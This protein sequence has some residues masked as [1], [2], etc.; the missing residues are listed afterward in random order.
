[1]I[2][3]K[4]WGEEEVW[5]DYSQ[6]VIGLSLPHTKILDDYGQPVMRITSSNAS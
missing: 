4:E 1:M 3:Q 6:A 5:G 2:G